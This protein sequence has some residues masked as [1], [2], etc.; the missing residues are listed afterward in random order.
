MEYKYYSLY[1]KIFTVF[2]SKMDMMGYQTKLY[3][4]FFIFIFKK[5]FFLIGR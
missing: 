4:F 3:T 1:F 5:L 2:R